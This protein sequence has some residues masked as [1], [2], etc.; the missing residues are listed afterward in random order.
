MRIADVDV[1]PVAHRE[2]PLRNSWGAHSELAARTIVVVTAADGTQGVAETYGDSEVIEGLEDARSLVVG[3]NPYETRPLRLQLQDEM[4]FGAIETAIYDLLGK[5][6]GQPVHS[7]LGGKI[8]D[9]VEYTG[10]LFYKYADSDPESAAIAP[11]EVMS[12]EAMV[13]MAREF[14]DKH[15]FR[16]LKLK[17]GVLKPDSELETLRLLAEEFGQETPLRI[18]PN[19]AW[20]VETATRLARELRE[21]PLRVQWLEDPVPSLHAHSRLKRNIDYPIATNMFVTEFD[22]IAPAIESD[23]VD[24]ILSDHHYWGG[25]T[26]NLEL[27]CVANTFDLGVGMHS[28]SHLGV[29]MAAMT[30][31]AAA[32]PTV[33]YTCDTHY[34]YMSEDVIE[35]AP[36]EFEDGH[37][38]VP[39]DPGLGVEL[40]ED[41]LERMNERYE[42]SETLGYSTVGSM[43]SEYADA[44]S[45]VST[46]QWLPNKPIW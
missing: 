26:G 20:S 9:S 24:V 4:V 31:V 16:V 12:S 17:A 18:D 35:D 3:M 13:D 29:S 38:A 28:N 44:M 5:L 36:I 43:A 25:L 6:T 41:E 46:E 2:P 10:Y 42:N 21:M 22:D 40:D 32:M 34:P 11:Q 27:D 39:D 33:R 14:V 19:G 45:E 7:L 23:A 1:V 30:H 15:G 37:V 8:R